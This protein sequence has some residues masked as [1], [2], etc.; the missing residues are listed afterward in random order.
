MEYGDAQKF[1]RISLRDNGKI[2]HLKNFAAK[3]NKAMGE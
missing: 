3:G 1:I 2:I